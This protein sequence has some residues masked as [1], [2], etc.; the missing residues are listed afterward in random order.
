MKKLIP[1]LV[2]A[3]AISFNVKGQTQI[4]LG[5]QQTTF[6]SMSRG[7]FFTAP[8]SFTICG[9]YIPTDASSDPSQSIEVVKFTAGAPPAYPSL[10][11]SFINLFYAQ[12]DLSNAIIPCSI[13]VNAGDIIGVYG[14]RDCAACVNSYGQANTVT[15]IYG[16]SVTLSRSGMQAN[17]CTGAMANIWSEVNYYIGRIFM[18]IDCCPPPVGP[19]SI[20]G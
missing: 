9:L 16:N 12:N 13:P 5:P 14:T 15:T 18:Y 3:F 4:A 8:V 6:S 20:N 11:N 19:S 7:Y 2:L 17:L 10:T 1:I